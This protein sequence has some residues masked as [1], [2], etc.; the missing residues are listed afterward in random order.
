MT[1]GRD[2]DGARG[3]IHLRKCRWRSGIETSRDL[4]LGRDSFILLFFFLILD[5]LSLSLIDSG[6]WGGLIHIVCIAVSVLLGLHTSEA[7]PRVIKVSAAFLAVGLIGAIIQLINPNHQV[8]AIAFFIM[9]VL[10]SVVAVSILGRILRHRHVSIETMFGAV[11]V[12][13]L[14]G[15]IFSSLF[16]GIA[17]FSSA[18]NLGSFLSQPGPHTSSDYVYLSY[19]TLT[20]VGFGDLTPH[21][22]LAR[23]VVVLEALIGQIFLVTLVARLVALFGMDQA[24]FGHGRGGRRRRPAT[25]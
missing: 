23:S 3:P 25:S 8:S 6:R 15:L 1:I 11:D 2:G 12:Y 10:L 14:I 7:H 17:L 19:V 18:H 16:I 4:I 13:I 20:T 5:Y 24:P 22:N 9:V 21:T